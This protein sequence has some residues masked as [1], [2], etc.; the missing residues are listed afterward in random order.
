LEQKGINGMEVFSTYFRTLLQS[1]AA[2]IFS[3]TVKATEGA[4]TYQILVSEIEKLH[5][6]LHQ[7]HKIAA[8]LDT[9]EGELFRDFDV[10]GLMN[11]LKLDAAGCISL[12]SALMSASKS[13][14]RSKGI[15]HSHSPCP[16][17]R[18]TRCSRKNPQR[19]IS[20]ILDDPH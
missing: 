3:G 20:A 19:E 14:L 8:A 2:Q 5:S 16:L 17:T 12:A 11:S 18:L 6:D 10:V 4:G 7:A 9:S 1:N 13:D 15:L